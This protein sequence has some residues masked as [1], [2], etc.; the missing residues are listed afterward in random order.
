MQFLQAVFLGAGPAVDFVAGIGLGDKDAALGI[1]REA[2][3][4][5]AER[6]HGFDEAIGFGVKNIKVAVRHARVFHDVR[7]VAERQDVVVGDGMFVGVER[8]QIAVNF[9]A[10]GK[11]CLVV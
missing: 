5:R 3:E 4:Q 7:L 11:L 2:V 10:A 1:H 8:D 6:V 9:I